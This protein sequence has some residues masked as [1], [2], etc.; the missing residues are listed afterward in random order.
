MEADIQRLCD[1]LLDKLNG[2]NRFDVVDEYA[3]PVPVAVI[4]K[5]LG[6]PLEDERHFHP[7]IFDHWRA[8]TWVRR[9]PPRKVR[10]ALRRA[11]SR[12]A[13][14]AIPA[15]LIKGFAREARRGT[16]SPGMLNEDGPDG[17]MCPRR[18]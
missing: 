9:Q 11:R 6:V 5:I 3:Y 14:R 8:S 2:K 1:D 7:W 4:C 13:V 18:L 16:A 15:E 17:P 12:D 10:P